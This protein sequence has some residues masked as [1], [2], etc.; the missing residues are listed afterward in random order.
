MPLYK[1]LAHIGQANGG[2]VYGG[3]YFELPFGGADAFSELY[4]I[5]PW[6][7]QVPLQPD[8]SMAQYFGRILPD[9]TPANPDAGEPATGGGRFTPRT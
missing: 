4:E 6:E 1:A 3:S 8:Q 9:G 5:A 7:M 2:I